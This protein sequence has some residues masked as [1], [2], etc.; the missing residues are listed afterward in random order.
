MSVSNSSILKFFT[1]KANDDDDENGYC[2]GEG[3][4][5]SYIDYIEI[6]NFKGFGAK[7][8]VPLGNPCKLGRPLNSVGGPVNSGDEPVKMGCGPVNPASG[9]VKM[10]CEPVSPASGPVKSVGEPVKMGVEFRGVPKTGGYYV[11]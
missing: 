9:P 1:T 5:M 10:G 3:V 6:E 7:V 2:D 11:L 8:R 4:A